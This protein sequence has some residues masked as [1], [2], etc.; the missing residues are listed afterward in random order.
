MRILAER[1][2]FV[3]F[4]VVGL[5]LTGVLYVTDKRL[6]GFEPLPIPIQAVIV[7]LL[8]WQVWEIGREGVAL[9]RKRRVDPILPP[10]APPPL[11]PYDYV[12]LALFDA[13]GELHMAGIIEAVKANG[14]GQLNSDAIKPIL[15]SMIT[16]G[17]VRDAGMKRVPGD[18]RKRARF[19]ALLP[20]GTT[21]A[22][23]LA[24]RND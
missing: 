4:V 24:G 1:V 9:V 19:Y 11:T 13:G 20:Y 5:A 8:L 2:A 14:G 23:K 12:L 7:L 22:R 3:V 17:R 21:A 16:E 6:Y 15:S 18:E 10:P